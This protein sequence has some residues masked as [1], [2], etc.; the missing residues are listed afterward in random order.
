MGFA[1]EWLALREPADRTAR[2]PAMLEA[3][4]Q[5]AVGGPVVDLGAGTGST[6][7]ALEPS[8]PESA[9]WR[10][11]DND[12]VLLALAK[13]Q[14]RG[15]ET[16]RCDLMRLSDLPLTGAGMVTSS[17]LLD[18]VSEAWL[19]ELV[20]RL[21]AEAMPFYAA[22]SYDGHMRW[23]PE[24]PLDRAITEAFNA[25]QR[26]DKGFGPALGPS[27]CEIATRLFE[28][29]GYAVSLAP[30]PWRLHAGHAGQAELQAQL[31]DGIA[32]AAARAGAASVEAWHR[33]RL[34]LLAG[35]ECEVGHLDLLAVPPA[36]VAQ[37][38][39]RGGANG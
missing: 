20:V 9:D 6:L 8:L 23:Q 17:A 14:H 1:P 25:D 5:L 34:S 28:G 32:E 26:R 30:S 7:R 15:I 39:R 4:A 31:L 16:F 11:V 27:A 22:L 29:A 13:A 38:K 24:L 33:E 21:T 10:L 36:M 19:A 37:R 2:D 3:A 35:G 12:A 18:L